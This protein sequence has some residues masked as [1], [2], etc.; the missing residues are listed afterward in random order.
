M[1]HSM[2]TTA[3]NIVFEGCGESRAEKFSSQEEKILNYARMI[4]VN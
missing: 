1:I 3:N 4:G 2:V